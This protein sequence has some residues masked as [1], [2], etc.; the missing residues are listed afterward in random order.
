LELLES[1]AVPAQGD[2]YAR[3]MYIEGSRQYKYHVEHYGY[4]S[5]VGYKDIIEMWKGEKF[6]PKYAG[7]YF[8]EYPGY[9]DTNQ[10]CAVNPPQEVI[11]DY[12]VRIKD[13]LDQHK[14]D[15]FY[16]DGEIPF[17]ESGR[18]MMAYYYNQ[19]MK[20]HNSKLEA[21]L[22]IKNYGART[23]GQSME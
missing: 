1:L 14:P 4:P 6:D 8:K 13:L 19:N 7:L 12:F 18:K 3:N 2:W 9:K 17:G 15:L 10:N 11:E 22:C 20:W 23:H 5:K 16:F 21:V